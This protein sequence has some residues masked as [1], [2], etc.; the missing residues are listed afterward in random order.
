MEQKNLLNSL[1]AEQ[2]HL[3]LVERSNLSISKLNV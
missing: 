3:N 2:L 1:L